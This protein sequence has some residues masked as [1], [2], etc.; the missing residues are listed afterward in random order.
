MHNAQEKLVQLKQ[1]QRT[2]LLKK[3]FEDNRQGAL[4]GI[5]EEELLERKSP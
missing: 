1:E 5:L 3:F 4:E 2:I